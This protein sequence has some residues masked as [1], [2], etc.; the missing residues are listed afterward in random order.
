MVFLGIGRVL[1]VTLKLKA[2]D[3]RRTT[4]AVV[5]KIPPGNGTLR[6]FPNTLEDALIAFQLPRLQH[7]GGDVS[8]SP[9]CLP[10]PLLQ[11]MQEVV[12]LFCSDQTVIQRFW[13][14]NWRPCVCKWLLA[15]GCADSA[16]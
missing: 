14:S 11:S 16:Y 7:S 3:K 1:V 10:P 13:L 8:V 12:D 9:T 15:L 4:V 5:F 6:S 2:S